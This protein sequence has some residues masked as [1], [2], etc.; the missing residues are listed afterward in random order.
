[1]T[2]FFLSQRRLSALAVFLCALVS[3][4]RR[5]MHHDKPSNSKILR[6]A[7]STADVRHCQ[8][9]EAASGRGLPVLTWNQ[10]NARNKP[11]AIM[12]ESEFRQ[13]TEVYNVHWACTRIMPERKNVLSLP[14]H[15]TRLD[16]LGP[17]KFPFTWYVGE[18]LSF[19]KDFLSM[20]PGP[21]DV[22]N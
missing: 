5:Q 10:R 17:M 3:G 11:E 12:T 2:R 22:R 15:S 1:M 6:E 9:Q 7:E 16:R 21:F 19:L 20:L 4:H 13:K 18:P 14:L 8:H